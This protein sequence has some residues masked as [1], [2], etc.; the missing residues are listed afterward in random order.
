MIH[1]HQY[2]SG[3]KCLPRLCVHSEIHLG[4]NYTP[5]WFVSFQTETDK[6]LEHP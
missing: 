6:E 3:G 2:Y 4:V 1:K 5:T